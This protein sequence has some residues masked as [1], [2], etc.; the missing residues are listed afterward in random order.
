VEAVFHTEEGSIWE[1]QMDWICKKDDRMHTEKTIL[2][3]LPKDTI[4]IVKT[5][6]SA[7]KGN[8]PLANILKR[9][10][11]VEVDI[12]GLDTND[13]VLATAMD[14]FDNGFLTHIVEECCDSSS[15]KRLHLLALNLLRHQKMTKTIE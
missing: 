12:V 14:S 15:S 6:K 3:A 5:T 7:F 8:K 13:C 2:G 1:K 9:A 4:H 10:H 11:I